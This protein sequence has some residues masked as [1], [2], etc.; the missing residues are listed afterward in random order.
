M[1]ASVDDLLRDIVAR[2]GGYVDHPDDRGGPTKSGVSLA[3]LRRTNR[4]VNGDGR[5]DEADVRAVTPA[6]ARQIYRA[7]FYEGPGIDR[8]P[9]ELQPAATDFAVHSGPGRA[10]REL[11]AT[12]DS[13]RRLAPRLMGVDPVAVDGVIGPQTVGA[14][15]RAVDAVTAP[16]L[17]AAYAAARLDYLQG[18]VDAD[19]DQQV[20]LDGWTRRVRAFQHVA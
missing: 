5:I 12:L 20:F 4:D 9:G 14:A 3:Y 6:R 10:V 11:Q 16:A 17:V 15:E 2:E 7:D 13:L 1:T 18:I 19:P 8:L